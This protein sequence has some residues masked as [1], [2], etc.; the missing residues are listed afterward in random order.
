M[1]ASASA[2]EDEQPA[3]A[4]GDRKAQFFVDGPPIAQARPR[5][6]KHGN[7]YNSQ[8]EDQLRWQARIVA[9]EVFEGPVAVRLAFSIARP[10]SHYNSKMKL[11]NN[12]PQ[13]HV[14]TPDTDNL[15]KFALDCMNGMVYRD[16]KQVCILSATKTW[17]KEA[18]TEVS[19]TPLDP[20]AIDLRFDVPGDTEE[21]CYMKTI[22]PP[23]SPL[24]PPLLSSSSSS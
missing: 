14:F 2:C 6:G 22:P 24:P 3:A 1:A 23:P 16:D 9:T 18:G 4:C 10:R 8:K 5:H 15:V 11:K 12:V 13:W 7:M 19:V 21:V 17:A 20:T